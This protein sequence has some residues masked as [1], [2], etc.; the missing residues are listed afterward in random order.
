MKSQDFKSCQ[1]SKTSKKSNEQKIGVDEISRV[2]PEYARG[3]LRL[4]DYSYDGA[5]QSASSALR[6]HT[7]QGTNANHAKL[8]DSAQLAQV[9]V[10][11]NELREA[12]VG[13]GLINGSA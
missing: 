11:V 2:R 9:I 4:C 6:P 1:I 8:E 10:L 13:K 7:V 5:A 12:L 3:V